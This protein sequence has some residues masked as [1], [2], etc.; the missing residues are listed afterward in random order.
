MVEAVVSYLSSLKFQEF[1]DLCSVSNIS[2]LIMDQYFHGYYIHGKAPWGKSD[3]VMG[4]LKEQ[5]DSEGM[6]EKRERGIRLGLTQE[7]DILRGE[8]TTYEI[9]FP[10]QLRDEYDNLYKDRASIS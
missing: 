8:V 10:V 9:Y 6:G 5:L 3:L 1:T 7:T 4:E 2:V